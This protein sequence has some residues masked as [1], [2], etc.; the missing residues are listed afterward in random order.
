MTLLSQLFDNSDLTKYGLLHA[1]LDAILVETLNNQ[2]R[3]MLIMWS[4]REL[5]VSLNSSN[6]RSKIRNIS[7]NTDFSSTD[8][9]VQLLNGTR[10]GRQV[11][12]E[13]ER[14]PKDYL[15]KISPKGGRKT[16]LQVNP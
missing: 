3:R 7:T 9:R 13:T 8:K 2:L 4:Q 10:I 11:R 15:S 1:V 5:V 14:G 16:K 6:K 12:K